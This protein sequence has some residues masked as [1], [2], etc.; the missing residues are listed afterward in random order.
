MILVAPPY[1]LLCIYH[2]PKR[3][4]MS[5]FLYS[6]VNFCIR[7]SFSVTILYPLGFRLFLL[8]SIKHT[9]EMEM[10]KIYKVGPHSLR[11]KLRIHIGTRQQSC[12]KMGSMAARRVVRDH[13][14]CPI[15]LQVM[16]APVMDPEGNTY[17]KAS[18]LAWLPRTPISPITRSPLTAALEC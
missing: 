14:S 7:Y 16:T 13:L 10:S 3:H 6:L 17:E 8:V 4:M 12:A 2:F 15:S 18:I 9:E 1:L 5:N 11:A